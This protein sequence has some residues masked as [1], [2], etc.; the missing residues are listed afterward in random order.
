MEKSFKGVTYDS[1]INGILRRIF[2]LS[3]CLL[4]ISFLITYFFLQKDGDVRIHIAENHT[5]WICTRNIVYDVF[6]EGCANTDTTCIVKK[7]ISLCA[8]MY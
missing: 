1:H 2:Y 6:Q 4:Y 7:I 3:V 5:F 8:G